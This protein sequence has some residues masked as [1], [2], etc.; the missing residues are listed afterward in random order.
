MANAVY[1]ALGI[2]GD[3]RREVLGLWIAESWR[4][5]E[6]IRGI[7]SPDNGARFWLSVMNELRNRGVQDIP[8]AVVP[9]HRMQA[10]DCRV[11]DGLKGFPEAINSA[12]SETTVNPGLRPFGA[13]LVHWTNSEMPLTLHRPSRPSLAEFLL[14]ERS[15]G[16]RSQVPGGLRHG[17]RR[18]GLGCPGSLRCRMGPAVFVHRPS[19]APGLAGGHSVLRI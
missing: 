6:T 16:S 15:K 18:D 10:F 8:I 7:V 5:Q 11:I 17:R 14:L 9:S 13:E 1:L 4:G 2:T 19:L 3:G 12:F